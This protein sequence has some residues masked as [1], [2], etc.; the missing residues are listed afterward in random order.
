MRM[1]W[2]LENHILLLIAE[3]PSHGYDIVARLRN[4]GFNLPGMGNMGTVYRLLNFLE[5]QGFI[6]SRWKLGDQGPPKKVYWLTPKGW[7]RLRNVVMSMKNLKME[8]DDFLMR[9]ERLKK[10]REKEGSEFDE[11]FENTGSEI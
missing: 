2:W 6:E 5:V 9:F 7:M 11:P 1:S 10:M 8:I 3:K 4:M